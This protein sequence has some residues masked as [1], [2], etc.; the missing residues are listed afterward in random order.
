MAGTPLKPLTAEE[1]S[2]IRPL[3]R[4]VQ[5]L[6]RAL[7]ADLDREQ[8]LSL[9]EYLTLMYLSE[10]PGRL[11]RMAGLADRCNLSL[12]G[13]TRIVS[14]LEAQGFVERVKCAEDLRGSNAVLTDAGLTRLEE[15][16]PTFLAG[17]RRYVFD[18]LGGIA[19]GPLGDA[20]QACATAADEA[21]IS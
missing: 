7:D 15:A 19:L 9:N 20:L 3:G 14:R 18:H 11:L 16:W 17:A 1:E 2:V 5:G 21:R 4:L 10:S 8:R 13:M 12:S 6:P